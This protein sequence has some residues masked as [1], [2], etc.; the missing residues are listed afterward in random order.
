MTALQYSVV[1][2]A[3]T[4]FALFLRFVFVNHIAESP[5]FQP[6]PLFLSWGS[7][8][9]VRQRKANRRRCTRHPPAGHSAERTRLDRH[10]NS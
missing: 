1:W 10:I 8:N 3:K 7:Q 4:L 5:V 9:E 2:S 6:F